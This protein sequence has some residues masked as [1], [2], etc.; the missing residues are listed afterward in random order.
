M[1]VASEIIIL[2]FTFSQ[3]S[4]ADRQTP[5][6]PI[7]KCAISYKIDKALQYSKSN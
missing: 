4:E 3:C 7:V 6:I 1:L 5:S 2:N